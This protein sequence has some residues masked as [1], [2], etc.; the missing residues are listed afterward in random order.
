MCR[1]PKLRLGRAHCLPL[2]RCSSIPE[3]QGIQDHR[4]RERQLHRPPVGDQRRLP[5]AAG[6]GLGQ[7]R[8]GLHE[9]PLRRV[10]DGQRA[11]KHQ[12]AWAEQQGQTTATALLPQPEGGRPVTPLLTSRS[13]YGRLTTPFLPAGFATSIPGTAATS[14]SW[15]PT[16]TGETTSTGESGAR[17][18]RPPRSSPSGASSSSCPTP[19]PP[20]LEH[21]FAR[22]LKLTGSLLVL[23]LPS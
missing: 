21:I 7:Q 23:I 1:C 4:L 14:T 19:G 16:T 9:D 15:R 18:P 11:T 20:T 17:T 2:T 8:S 10:S 6:H 12:R 22:F 3:P 5:L 13:P